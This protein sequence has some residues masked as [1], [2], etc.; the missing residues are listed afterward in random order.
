MAVVLLFRAAVYVVADTP[1]GVWAATYAAAGGATYLAAVRQ[2]VESAVD[3]YRRGGVSADE[4]E[5]QLNTGV[6]PEIG[7]VWNMTDFA[8]PFELRKLQFRMS[9]AP[10]GGVEDVDVNTFHFIKASG[11]TP[12]AWVDGTDLPALEGFVT[13]YWAAIKGFFPSFM[14]A[15]QYRWYKDGPAFYELN[16]DGTAYVPIGAGNPAVRVTEVDVAGTGSPPNLPP[17]DA[18]TITERTSS[19]KHWG[20]WYLPAPDASRVTTEGRAT[21]GTV[22]SL[23]GSAVSFYN[24]CRAAGYVPVVFSI[25]KP[26]RPKKPS[27]TLP[28]EPAVAYEV[29][30]LQM[31]DIYDVIRSRRWANAV[32]KTN[33]VLT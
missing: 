32:V 22:S 23:L 5:T 27:G 8:S 6:D 11:G 26:V 17:Q 20:R 7:P 1:V 33:T 28:A 25:Q 30:S 14:H 31:D 4:I 9:R 16:G 2:G 18:L 10:S 15:D 24:S 29:L 13:T 12:A 3:Y 21:S 19:R